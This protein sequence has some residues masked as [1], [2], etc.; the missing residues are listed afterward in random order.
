MRYLPVYPW[1]HVWCTDTRAAIFRFFC[2]VPP[3]LWNRYFSISAKSITEK[4]ISLFHHFS[5]QFL[6]SFWHHFFIPTFHIFS[7]LHQKSSFH[8]FDSNFNQFLIKIHPK[9]WKI[10]KFLKFQKIDD[11][12]SFFIIFTS[13]FIHISSFH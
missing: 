4:C 10:Q 8:I 1:I 2:K 11:F 3:L 12:S 9:I 13:F 7:H 6:I 5:Y